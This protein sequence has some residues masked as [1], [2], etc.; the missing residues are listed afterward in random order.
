MLIDIVSVCRYNVDRKERVEM[1]SKSSKHTKGQGFSSVERIK[2]SIEECD[3]HQSESSYE[4]MLHDARILSVAVSDDEY[5]PKNIAF[6]LDT[7][8]AMSSA[9]HLILMGCS[10]ILMDDLLNCWWLGEEIKRDQNGFRLEAECISEHDEIRKL[11]VFCKEI[12]LE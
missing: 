8:G 11:S 7:K 6:K 9:H 1:S 3:T 10:S 2:Y 4:L 12:I 5:K